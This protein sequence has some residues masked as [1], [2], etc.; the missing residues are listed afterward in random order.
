[1]ESHPCIG[2]N[3]MCCYNV[4][5]QLPHY[6][7]PEAVTVK[8]SAEEDGIRT[9]FVSISDSSTK[10]NNRVLQLIADPTFTS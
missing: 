6:V 9:S 1:M 8:F 3:F 2:T 10:S 4:V 5:P 7:Q